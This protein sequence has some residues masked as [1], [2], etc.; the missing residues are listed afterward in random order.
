MFFALV[1]NGANSFDKS[2]SI[3]TQVLQLRTHSSQKLL[4]NTNAVSSKCH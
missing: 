1:Q 4:H 3:I 2:F